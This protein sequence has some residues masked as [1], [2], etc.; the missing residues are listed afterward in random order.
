[1]S[2]FANCLPEGYGFVILTGVGST[3]VNMWMA[4]NVMKARKKYEVEVRPIN[5]YICLFI[6]YTTEPKY[7]KLLKPQFGGVQ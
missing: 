5:V 4:V 3:F 7:L 1:M 6:L 2:K